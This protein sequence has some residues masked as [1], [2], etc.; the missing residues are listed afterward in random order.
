MRWLLPLAVVTASLGFAS[1]YSAIAKLKELPSKYEGLDP[2]YT[3][4][5]VYGNLEI[6]E[7]NSTSNSFEGS[8]N[9]VPLLSVTEEILPELEAAVEAGSSVAAIALADIYTFGNHSV[10]VN[11]TKALHL[12]EHAVSIAPDGHAYFM[13][14]F[15]YATGMFGEVPT[16]K[17][18]SNLYYEFA[19]Q[20]GDINA[21]L[22][23][24]NKYHLGIGRPADCAVAQF[25][26]SKLAR[27]A[28]AYLHETGA[29][30]AN[31]NVSY[32]INLADFNGGIYRNKVSESPSSVITKVN[33]LA[34]TRNW[35]RENSINS[36]DSDLAELYFDAVEHYHGN[37]FEEK[38]LTRAF[39]EALQCAYLGTQKFNLSDGL[40]SRIDEWVWDKC[41]N[42]VGHMYLKGHGVER[43]LKRANYWLNVAP[44]FEEDH[45]Y[46]LDMALLH[47]LDP[48][49]DGTISPTCEFHLSDAVKNGSAQA[50]Y[51]LSKYLAAGTKSPFTTS[52]LNS[53]YDLLKAAYFA[54]N[55]EATF[56]LA[57]AVESGFAASTGDKYSCNDVVLLYKSFVERSESFL[58]PHLRYAFEEFKYGNFKNALLGYSIAA[59]QGLKNAQLSAAYLLYQVSPLYQK[60][61]KCFDSN[62]RVQSSLNYL[63]L[64]SIQGHIDATI[65]LGDV[66]SQGVPSANI[67][68]DYNKAFA[69]YSKAAL[70]ASAHGCYKLGYMYEYGLGTTNNTVDY[71]MAKRY[72]DLSSKSYQD[73]TWVY[74]KKNRPNTYP[75]SLALL[76]LRIKVL[77]SK[78]SKKEDD[79]DSSG[80]LSTFKKLAEQ[81]ANEELEEKA[82]ARSQAHHEGGTFEDEG[83]YEFFDYVVLFIFFAF[84]IYLGIQN[85]QGQIRRARLNRDAPVNGEGAG[86]GIQGENPGAN[87]QFFFLAV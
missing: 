71:Y 51:K 17:Q 72:Y 25:Y 9:A 85:I 37:H 82:N 5:N 76:R 16:C 77:F 69:Y 19:A 36:H 39:R 30:P 62:S 41:L 66:Y 15:M 60:H 48:T 27:V 65:L 53:T 81:E 61:L 63:E 45:K 35:V 21:L 6:P 57:D 8:G 83:D 31:E 84:F 38:N 14:G 13:L 67:S 4:A 46:A 68:T 42:L 55:Y 56:Y 24:A 23:L 32:N 70:A 10:P 12:Y 3:N 74:K 28:M 2:I 44:G 73:L 52:Y 26:Y 7:Y 78:D 58:L 20:N 87:F 50:A 11:Y 64:A 29:E 80:W 22:V 79:Q 1:Y 86:G 54:D 33:Q 43:N 49:T 75:V 18:K 34:D 40:L 59:E 47:E